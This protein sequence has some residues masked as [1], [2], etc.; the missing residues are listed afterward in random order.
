MGHFKDLCNRLELLRT[1]QLHHAEH[2]SSGRSDNIKGNLNHSGCENMNMMSLQI[3]MD[4]GKPS[5]HSGIHV[6]MSTCIRVYMYTCIRTTRCPRRLMVF[7][8]LLE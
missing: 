8:R 1:T 2:S 4:G 3:G 6:Y 7:H 5:K